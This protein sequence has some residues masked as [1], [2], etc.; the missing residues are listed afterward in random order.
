MQ[1]QDVITGFKALE[2]SSPAF[3]QGG[4]IPR[5]YTCDGDDVNPPI[6]V[7]ELP[8]S[9]RSL[10]LIVD[11]PDAPSGTWLHWLV[12]N[13]AITRHIREKEV[14][15]DQGVNDFGR[16]TYG[17]PCPPSGTHR[18]FF[19]IYA[20]DDLLD[21]PEGSTRHEVESAMREHIIGYGELMGVYKR[22]AR[23]R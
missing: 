13:I 19:R 23:N 14:P 16:N 17:G 9:T 21:L 11:D 6:D 8:S 10:T 22:A 12:W 20:L 15:G 5:R 1:Q 2:I 3:R 7:G 18:Y 4:M